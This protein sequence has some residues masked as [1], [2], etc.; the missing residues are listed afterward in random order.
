MTVQTDFLERCKAL[1][2]HDGKL[3]DWLD[4]IESLRQQLAAMEDKYLVEKG[5]RR[6]ASAEAESL[7]QQLASAS[8]EIER[9]KG[10]KYV[11]LGT[12]SN[13][14]KPEQQRELAGTLEMGQLL[15]GGSHETAGNSKAERK[16]TLIDDF[17]GD[18]NRLVASATA[19][20]ELDIEGALVPHGIGGHARGLLSALCIRVQELRQ[21][22]AAEIMRLEIALR[23]KT[24][25]HKCCSEDLMKLRESEQSGWKEAAMA[26]EVCGSIH[27]AFAKKKDALYSTRHSDFERHAEDARRMLSTESKEKVE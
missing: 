25:E 6:L 17:R 18:L 5:M 8:D 4:E 22:L 13:P 20:V 1:N 24:E 11:Q 21:Q 7:R 2:L 9:L 19:L 12:N 26:W 10:D 23:I 16:V 3:S 27:E 14:A 15:G